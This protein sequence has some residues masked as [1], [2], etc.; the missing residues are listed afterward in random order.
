MGLQ[1]DLSGNTSGTTGMTTSVGGVITTAHIRVRKIEQEDETRID[2]RLRMWLSVEE[3]NAGKR[4]IW[5]EEI[6]LVLQNI[7][8]TYS[9]AQFAN[10]DNG[11]LQNIIKNMLEDG[12]SNSFIQTLYPSLIWGGLGNGT[13]T[14]I[15][16]E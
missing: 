14:V 10:A 6:P 5:V 4:D 9:A 2:L 13:V 1:I 12:D 15:M 16:P 3:F 8:S 7:V 11:Q